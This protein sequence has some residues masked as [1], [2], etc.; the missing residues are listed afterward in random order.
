[1]IAERVG[2]HSSKRWWILAGQAVFLVAFCVGPALAGET[3]SDQPSAISK[4]ERIS[5]WSTIR[6]GGVIGYLI[7]LM[8]LA[9]VSLVTEYFLSIR[10]ERLMPSAL[11]KTLEKR[12]AAKEYNQARQACQ[13]DGSFLSHLAR[14]RNQQGRKRHVRAHRGTPAR[15]RCLFLRVHN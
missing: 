4:P 7:I 3:P 15:D 14:S 6:A 8:S 1:M 5:L 12:L 9:A 2:Q 13:N 10:R 11:V